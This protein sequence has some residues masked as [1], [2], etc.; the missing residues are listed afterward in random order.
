[1]CIRDSSTSAN[2]ATVYAINVANTTEGTD[3]YVKAGVTTSSYPAALATGA[4][5]QVWFD[6]ITTPSVMF[7][8][9]VPTSKSVMKQV[10]GLTAGTQ[11]VGYTSI[12]TSTN[13]NVT[14]SLGAFNV[15]SFTKG[16]VGSSS[17]GAARS[18]TLSWGSS[19]GATAYQIQ[20]FGS[21]DNVNW[22]TVQAF[23]PTNNIY[24]TSDTKT[25]STSGGNF[26]YYAFMKASVRAVSYTHLTLP[27]IY[28]V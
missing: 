13:Q 22:T 19:S 10:T 8:P 26:G 3:A 14:P 17:Q 18:T 27:T 21:N 15:S 9:Y 20:Y 5:R 23:S 1:M 16:T 25:W 28:S 6:G 2:Y 24:T 4:W 12:V 11:D 7:G